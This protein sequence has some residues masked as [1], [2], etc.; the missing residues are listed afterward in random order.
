M[1]M[2][3]TGTTLSFQVLE[4]T[5]TTCITTTIIKLGPSKWPRYGMFQSRESRFFF[6]FFRELSK[7]VSLAI[8]LFQIESLEAFKLK[9][10]QAVK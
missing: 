1:M 10:L 8:L 7:E 3:W 2:G 4:E 5:S 6:S 9:K